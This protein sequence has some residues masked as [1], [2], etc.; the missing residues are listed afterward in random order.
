M[1]CL[2]EIDPTT[3]SVTKSWGP[4]GFGAVDGLAFWGGTVYGFDA[5]GDVIAVTF[6]AGSIATT[7]LPI[8]PA[9]YHFVGAGSSMAAP[10]GTA[11]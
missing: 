10:L 7:A 5:A 9:G 3:G 11:Q 4:L 1:D 6:D 8:N 2:V